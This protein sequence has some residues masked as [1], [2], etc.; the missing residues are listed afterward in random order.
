[1]STTTTERSTL[2]LILDYEFTGLNVA[3]TLELF[4][5]LIRTG[6]AWTLQGSYG[7]AASSLIERGYLT[8]K[9]DL[10]DAGRDAAAEFEEA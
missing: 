9:G 2:D 5:R 4:S 8:D 1:M 6:Q 10:T 7:R 3:E